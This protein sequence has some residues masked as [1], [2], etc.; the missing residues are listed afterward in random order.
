MLNE[1]LTTNH[2]DQGD[3]NMDNVDTSKLTKKELKIWNRMKAK[4]GVVYLKGRPGIAKSAIIRSICDKLKFNF[5]DLRL[6]VMDETDFGMPGKKEMNIAGKMVEVMTT[7]IPEW[8]FTTHEGPT[9][10]NFEELNRCPQQVHNAAMGV[11][12]ERLVHNTPLGI[13]TF[14]VATGNLGLEDGTH[15]EELD[16]AMKNRVITFE[17]DLTIDEW[18]EGYAGENVVPEIVGF[19]KNNPTHF[20]KYTE[21][22]EAFATPRSWTFLSD[23]IKANGGDANALISTIREDG[24]S[25][26]G[27]SAIE[28]V[29]YLEV[30]QRINIKM[31]LKDFDKNEKK[32]TDLSRVDLTRLLGDLKEEYPTLEKLTDKQANNLEKFITLLDEDVKVEWIV[33]IVDNDKF[34]E[35]SEKTIKFLRRKFIKEAV[36]VAKSH[37]KS[38]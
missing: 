4:S 2:H 15:T 14:M 19:I 26:V 13:D 31:V 38:S 8:V 36:A 22:S 11:L 33:S 21:N 27:P 30:T 35:K 16:T 6:S 5:I 24:A 25:Y 23:F 28:F 29:R 34:S 32:I 7:A 37:N 17:Y 18:I 12:Q 10:I 9:I 20:Y 3:H 1:E